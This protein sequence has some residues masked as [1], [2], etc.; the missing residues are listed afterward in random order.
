ML[1]KRI[2]DFC[3]AQKILS[4]QQFGFRK[5]HST[6]HALS[7]LTNYLAEKLDDSETSIVVFLDLS[8]AFET[9]D[10]KILLNK[11][12]YYGISG[13]PL[14]LIK[15]YLENRKQCVKCGNHFSTFLEVLCG[16]PQGSILGPLL[17]LLYVNDLPVIIDHSSILF[18]D[19]TSVLSS[20]KKIS[21]VFCDINAKLAKLNTWFICNKLTVNYSK[22]NYI[23]FSGNRSKSFN[24]NVTMGNNTL[25][26]VSSAKYLG[27]QFDENLNWKNHVS[28]LC[29]KISNCSNIMYKLRHFVPL[30]SCISVYYSL[31]YS[32]VSYGIVCWGSAS[33]D[34]VNPVRVLQN[35]IIRTML[36][37]P[38][39]TRIKSLFHEL[40]LLNV[41][42]LFQYEIS[43]HV[44]KSLSKS[45]PCTFHSQYIYRNTATRSSS[46]N[47]LIINRTKKD[48]GKKSSTIIGATVW[49]SIPHE[50]RSLDY[51]HFTRTYKDYLIDDY[52][53]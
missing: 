7:T 15:S 52:T 42:D 37:K 21:T 33:N 18:A 30:A 6:Q 1:Y 25:E 8:K 48:I 17:F 44:H 3:K 49:N 32:K 45:L 38:I 19:D 2:L 35:R 5:K 36:F 50:M 27:I 53:E 22:T 46:R 39:D 26:R 31:F 43:K 34:V 28:Y 10:H 29:K 41:K 24:F 14:E 4:D 47:E 20:S 13:L 16:V 12:Y 11:L 23:I 51:K 40:Q 9:V